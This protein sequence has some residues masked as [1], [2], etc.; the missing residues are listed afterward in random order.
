MEG[1][2]VSVVNG[3]TRNICHCVPNGDT[4][5]L[6]VVYDL[7]IEGGPTSLKGYATSILVN[8]LNKSLCKGNLPG[9]MAKPS[10]N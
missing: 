5:I 7:N 1:F 10:Q 2:F 4:H 8:A 3:K 6:A 9:E